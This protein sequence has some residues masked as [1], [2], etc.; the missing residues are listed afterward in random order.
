MLFSSIT[1]LYYFLPVLLLIYFIAPKRAKNIVLLSASLL[2]YFWGEPIYVLLMLC[3]TMVGYVCGLLIEK[4]R[5]KVGSKI[6]LLTSLIVGIGSLMIFKYTDFFINTINGTLGTSIKLLEIAL[7]IGI[8]FY[9]FQILSYTIDL[10]KGDVMVQRSFVSF[11]TYVTLFPQ[12]IAG[13]IVRY[14]DVAK[15]IDN[16]STNL[17]DLSSGISRFVMGLGVKILIA[18]E[19]GK[20]CEI[21]KNSHERSLLFVWMYVIAYS[22][23]IYFDFSGYSHMAIGLGR[24]F[25]FHFPENF[26]YPYI[27]KSITEFWRRWHIS[28]GTWFRDYVYIP[29]GGNKVSLIRNL[30]NITLVWFLTG[31]WHG[32]GWTFIIWGLYFAAFLM[33]EKFV[34]KKVFSKMPSIILHLYTILVISFG[35][36]IFD[37]QNVNSAFSIMKNMMGIGINGLAGVESLY[38]F[39][40]Y[41]GVFIVAIIG[42]TPI[43]SYLIK[44]IRCGRQGNVV[45]ILQPVFVLL[46]MVAI[47]AYLVDGSFNPFIYFRF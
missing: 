25:G 30:F 44:K 26:N 16:R 21:Y 41:V 4:Y 15:E 10:F 19:L 32:A 18:N 45:L 20:L 14:S 23:H 47:T 1:F 17:H 9:T 38:Y 28:L 33:I 24:I 36:V 13:P 5:G 12:L 2:F 31:F 40:S 7:P 29:L 6:A 11:A 35:W 43:P 8:S 3:T 37:A 27:S 39:R 42:C 46:L 22:L 34:L